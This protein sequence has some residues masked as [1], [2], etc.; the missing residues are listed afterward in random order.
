VSSLVVF[1]VLCEV[2]GLGEEIGGILLP[3][4]PRQ[5]VRPYL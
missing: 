1:E 5:K 3:G 4:Q 2:A